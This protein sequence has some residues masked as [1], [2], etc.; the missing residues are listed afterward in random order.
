MPETLGVSVREP[1]TYRIPLFAVN[2]SPATDI[3]GGRAVVEAAVGRSC[4]LV[5]TK[6]A[7]ADGGSETGTPKIV[8]AEAPG[9]SVWESTI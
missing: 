6:S 2:V 5:P 8:T 3:I 1:I 4:V 7:V 9:T